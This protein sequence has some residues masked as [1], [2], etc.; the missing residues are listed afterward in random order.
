MPC[1]LLLL[2]LLGGFVFWDWCFYTRLRNQRIEG[3]RLILEG[4]YMGAWLAVTAYILIWLLSRTA[5]APSVQQVWFSLIPKNIEYLG[6]AVTA[7]LLGPGAALLI[8]WILS[9]NDARRYQ[10]KRYA[11]EKTGEYMLAL[12]H[13]ATYTGDLV[14]L[15]IA[16]HKVYTGF[17]TLAPNLKPETFLIFLP[18]IVGYEDKDTLQKKLIEKRL[19]WLAGTSPAAKAKSEQVVLPMKNIESARFADLSTLS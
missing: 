17:V 19:W 8:N 14:E 15:I 16:N 1:N 18:V 9:R 10:A 13:E 2:S 7:F 4:A 3:N 12:F 5:F 11:I 6:T